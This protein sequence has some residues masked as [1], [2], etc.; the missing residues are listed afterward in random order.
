MT[1]Q[2]VNELKVLGVVS[3]VF[4]ATLWWTLENGPPLDA[5]RE[6]YAPRVVVVHP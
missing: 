1:E 3:L 5:I 2:K 6:F 4:V